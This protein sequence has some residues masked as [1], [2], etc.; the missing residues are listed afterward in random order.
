MSK[1]YYPTPSVQAGPIMP[2]SCAPPGQLPSP[3]TNIVV[4]LHYYYYQHKGPRR[5]RNTFFLLL[6]ALD[7]TVLIIICAIL[8]VSSRSQ[9]LVVLAVATVAV[10]HADTVAEPEQQ[11]VAESGKVVEKRGIYGGYSGVGYQTGAYDP[12]YI[13]GGG[14]GL[15]Y[16]GGVAGGL[17][18]YSAG[19]GGLNG[20]YSS[21]GYYSGYY[22]KA[23]SQVSY[24]IGHGGNRMF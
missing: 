4:E 1:A 22:P 16:A 2:P 23:V 9:I 17:G 8:C 6:H 18:G 15:G 7:N 11:Q 10:V 14:A 24:T 12:S 19:L 21:G 20:G 13:G 3:R 5:T